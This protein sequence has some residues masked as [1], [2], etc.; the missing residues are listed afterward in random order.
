[1]EEG[2]D[3]EDLYKDGDESAE[4]EEEEEDEV[5][6]LLVLPTTP[7]KKEIGRSSSLIMSNGRSA[8]ATE[9]ILSP[10]QVNIERQYSKF[11]SLHAV[12][13]IR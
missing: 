4:E 5:K 6:P 7:I 8:I 3:I 12:F 11:L 1:M 13:T 2:Y 9:N 10:Y